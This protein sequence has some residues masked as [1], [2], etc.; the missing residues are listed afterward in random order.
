MR[1]ILDESLRS[2]HR[3]LCTPRLVH[4]DPE[5]DDDDNGDDEKSQKLRIHRIGAQR[6]LLISTPSQSQHP[7]PSGKFDG[8]GEDRLSVTSAVLKGNKQPYP[9]HR[10]TTRRVR[11]TMSP[12]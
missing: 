12:L 2:I 7:N 11:L 1:R 9:A 3:F 8:D 6:M 4:E 5:E 10:L